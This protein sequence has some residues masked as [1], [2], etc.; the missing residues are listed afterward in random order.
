VQGH[1]GDNAPPRLILAETVRR[2]NETWHS[3]RLRLSTNT[4]FFTDAES[5]LGDA[6]PAFEGDWGDWWVEGVG[7]GARPQAMVRRAQS[8][9]T[10]AATLYGIAALTSP[11]GPTTRPPRPA[12]AP[13]RCTLGVPVQRA[14]LGRRRPVD[15]R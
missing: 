15:P 11:A 8:T 14:H 1:F 6:I 13:T 2:W 10:D 9:V 12:T 5:R 3:P 7:S 4:D